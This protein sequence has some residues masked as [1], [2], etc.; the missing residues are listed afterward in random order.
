MT[1]VHCVDCGRAAPSDPSASGWAEY[2]DGTGRC[3]YCRERQPLERRLHEAC[4]LAPL[5]VAA[6]E[7]LFWDAIRESYPAPLLPGPEDLDG[8]PDEKPRDG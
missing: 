2:R 7:R 6:S 4:L 3:L 8:R 1:S 5:P